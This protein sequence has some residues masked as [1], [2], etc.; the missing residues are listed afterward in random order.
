MMRPIMLFLCYML[1]ENSLLCVKLQGQ[2]TPDANRLTIS[3][4]G[5]QKGR[6]VFILKKWNKTFSAAD[7]LAD[8]VWINDSF[9]VI[10]YKLEQPEMAILVSSFGSYDIYITRR[11]H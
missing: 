10:S 11:Q 5:F 3:G 4:S 2:S 7:H 9:F 8:P 1:L 6:A